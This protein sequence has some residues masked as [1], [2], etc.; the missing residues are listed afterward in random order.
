MR[1]QGVLPWAPH[2]HSL[3]AARPAAQLHGYFP[4]ISYDCVESPP[5]GLA[6]VLA[7]NSNTLFTWQGRCS[8]SWWP[9]AGS[10][11]LLVL[12]NPSAPISQP[13]GSCFL[14]YDMALR[15]SDSTCPRES[16]AWCYSHQIVRLLGSD[17]AE[18]TCQVLSSLA[19]AVGSKLTT[20]SGDTVYG[21]I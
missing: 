19:F 5:L 13:R 10:C 4:F 18:L 11:G 1:S 17:N 6:S 14:G 20:F 3:P 21:L 12:Q 7:F 2:L 15:C 8:P 16:W 9:G